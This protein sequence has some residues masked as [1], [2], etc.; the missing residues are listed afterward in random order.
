M[1]RPI[2][3]LPSVNQRLPSG[4]AAIPSGKLWSVGIANS[5]TVPE[6]VM[7]PILLPLDSVNQRLPSGPLVIPTGSPLA[8]GIGN[9]VMLPEG[10]MRPILLALTSVNQ[11]LPSGPATIPL[12][13][14]SIWPLLSVGMGM[15]T[16][17]SVML[18][19]GLMR[20]I[21][22]ALTSVNQ[23]LP[24]GPATISFG[25][26]PDRSLIVVSGNSVM[27]PEGLMRP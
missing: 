1:M 23:R 6:G 17:N 4:P 22:L 5:V 16:G 15:G 9:A 25:T 2:L 11:R 12:R 18:P 10:L 3:P 7:R 21:R 13:P 8:V 19:E 14:F 26:L 24:S 27:L 20:P